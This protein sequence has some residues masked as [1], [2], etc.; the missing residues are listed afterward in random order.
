MDCGKNGSGNAE[1]AVTE[2]GRWTAEKMV[3]GMRK[4]TYPQFCLWETIV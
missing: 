3:V 1:N 4:T 2:C